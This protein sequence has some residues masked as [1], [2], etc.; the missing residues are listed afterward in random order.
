MQKYCMRTKGAMYDF[1][2]NTL[3]RPEQ[4]RN[5]EPE[6]RR[7]QEPHPMHSPH[8]RRNNQYMNNFKIYTLSL[9]AEIIRRRYRYRSSLLR[10]P[11]HRITSA[12]VEGRGSE[13][14]RAVT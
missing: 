6:P 7:T 13:H 4:T 10:L 1:I 2:K 5:S 12:C 11:E 8:T 14:E 9:P 3:R